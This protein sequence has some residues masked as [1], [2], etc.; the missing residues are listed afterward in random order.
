MNYLIRWRWGVPEVLRLVAQGKL[1]PQELIARE[2]GLEEGARAIMEMDKGSPLGM[3]M[4][5]SF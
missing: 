4:V 5:T 1:R 2:V 3:T